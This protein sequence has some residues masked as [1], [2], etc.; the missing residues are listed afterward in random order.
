MFVEDLEDAYHFSIFCGCTGQPFWSCVFTID[1]TCAIV[2]RWRL[3][4]GC[5]VYT[6]LGLCDKAISSFCI[7]GFVGCFAA[8]HFGQRNAGSPLNALMRAIQ[9]FLARRGAA[10]KPK[11]TP[12]GRMKFPPQPFP[13][14][15]SSWA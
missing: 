12:D 13:H 14:L 15:R 10:P 1:E 3:V 8:A 6:C 2:R 9:R 7:D 5:D 4:M 11:S